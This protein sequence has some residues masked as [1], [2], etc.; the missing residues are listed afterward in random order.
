MSVE[1]CKAV[2]TKC[3][4]AISISSID[5]DIDQM[6]RD[7]CEHHGHLADQLYDGGLG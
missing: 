1:W 5:P 4:D 3:F 2:M 7:H 6:D